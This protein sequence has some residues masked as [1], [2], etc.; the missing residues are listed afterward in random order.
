MSG[1]EKLIV[2]VLKDFDYQKNHLYILKGF[3]FWLDDIGLLDEQ[4]L[5]N[6]FDVGKSLLDI[7]LI[8]E[9]LDSNNPLFV[10]HEQ[11]SLIESN[12]LY[13]LIENSS[14]KPFL[15]NN[16]FF[17]FYYPGHCKNYDTKNLQKALDEN[18]DCPEQLIYN[19]LEEIGGVPFVAY[20]DL[21]TDY[22]GLLISQEILDK[23]EKIKL[24]PTK[25]VDISVELDS[26]HIVSQVLKVI[27]TDSKRI[28]ILDCRNRQVL[29]SYLFEFLKT[30]QALGGEISYL[31]YKLKVPDSLLSPRF[32]S[33]EKILQRKDKSFQFYDID[34]YKNPYES[35]NLTKINQAEIIDKIVEN[36]L[37][38]QSGSIP[39]DIFV[40]APTGSGKSVMFQ[41]P[42][43]YL[44]EN[45]NLLTLVLTPLI[46][47]MNDQV[48]GIE[49]MT[50]KAA[51][52]NSDYTPAQREMTKKRIKENEISIL[53]LS[54]EVL[55]SNSDI[56][57]LIGDRKIGLLVVDEAHIVSTWG[58]TF[59][60]DYWY[61][62][63]F[64]NRLRHT[65]RSDQ[66]FPIATFTATATFGAKDSMFLD[67][68]DSLQMTPIKYIGNVKRSDIEFDIKHHQMREGEDYKLKKLETACSVL[69]EIKLQKEKTLV[70]VPY[71]RHIVDLNDKLDFSTG[72]YFAGLPAGEKRETVHS[73][74]DGSVPIVLA[75]KAFGMGIDIDDIKNIYHYAPTGNISDYVQE[76]GRAARDKNMTGIAKTDFFEEDFRYINQLYGMSA[77][78][79]FHV[80]AV[81][82]KIYQIYRK[83]NNRN[84][85]LNPSNFSHIFGF[86]NLDEVD[87]K[88]K[89]T[90][91]IIKKD[92]EIDHMFNYPPLIFKPRGMFTEGY[93][94]VKDN[95]LEKLKNS[96]FWQFFKEYEQTRSYYRGSCLITKSGNVFSLNFKAMWENKFKD[97][98]F[99]QF[100][101]HFYKNELAGFVLNIDEDIIEES[102]IKIFLSEKVI[103]IDI[104]NKLFDFLEITKDIFND[105][106][107]S[108]KKF[109]ISDLSKAFQDKLRLN[110][111]KKYFFDT[112]AN[113]IIPLLEQVPT[114]S[115][116]YSKFT[117]YNQ[118]A[119]H[120]L[121]KSINYRRNISKLKTAANNLL[122]Y[123]TR[124][125]IVKP[126][127]KKVFDSDF[128]ICQLIE[129]LEL[130]ECKI[131]SGEKPEFF[132]RVNNPLVI[133]KIIND[134]HYFS[135]TVSNIDK[136]HKESCFLMK[137]FFTK[138]KTDQERWGFIEKIFLGQT[139]APNSLDLNS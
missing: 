126:K 30:F 9:K 105:F 42:A 97:L 18:K 27:Q 108:N 136:K 34:V 74:K 72:R 33:Y 60:P 67:I 109:K 14:Y 98:S 118:V 83:N 107:K 51:T 71:K 63:D 120:Y 106:K 131:Y 6:S 139:D 90:L 94:L 41:V 122:K 104:L 46:A 20:C 115:L 75:T 24:K 79:N 103:P 70:Y 56:T 99:G 91:L 112:I 61:V 17:K 119:G 25:S 76:V 19:N 1:L 124:K 92:F 11:V 10:S 85:L 117:T 73:L 130:A 88:L 66:S 82:N 80:K 132:V 48:E 101:H 78:K 39:D 111:K 59:R 128:I 87:T 12:S 81:L 110:N 64:I 52:I 5:L 22:Q 7:R 114:R 36:V 44:A 133:E 96:D 123:E 32:K 54:P 43:I 53:Y 50:N 47:L 62:G 137:Y 84:F 93:F 125:I 89:T 95:S 28:N 16:D 23:K 21:E 68:V 38:A 135:K 138:L 77:I 86:K 65:K 49:K 40:T 100:K 4:K 127:H 58:K 134:E 35:N 3:N 129:L 29:N 116:F 37:L 55:L 57:G 121:V 13:G 113:S 45:Q 26:A 69:S 15:L 102:I 31:D 8:L 2:K